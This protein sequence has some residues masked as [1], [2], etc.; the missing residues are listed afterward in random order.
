VGRFVSKVIILSFLSFF[1]LQCSSTKYLDNNAILLKKNKI[2]ID[3][4]SATNDASNELFID[5]PNKTFIGVPFEIFFNQWAKKDPDS[6]FN[7]WLS[8][9]EKRQQ[10]WEKILSPKQ[11]TQVLRYKKLSNQWLK[12]IGAPAVLLDS[13]NMMRNSN[14]LIQYFKNKGYFDATLTPDVIPTGQRKAEVRYSIQKGQQYRLDSIQFSIAA[15]ELEALVTDNMQES[16]LIP[17]A[18][19]NIDDFEAERKRMLTLFRNAGVYNFQEN[20]LSF[21]AAIDSSGQDKFIGI[22]MAIDNPKIRV[23]DSLVS[24]PYRIHWVKRINIFIESQQLG[25]GLDNYSD[26]TTYNGIHIYSKGPLKYRPKALANSLFIQKDSTYSDQERLLTYRYFNEL[27]NFKYPSITYQPISDSL[28][29]LETNIRLT[30]K[31]KFSLGLDF[32]LS[33]SNIQFFGLGL[34]T[35]TAIRNV[36]GGAEVLKVGVQSSFG[37]SSNNSEQLSRFFDLFELGSDLNLQIPRLLLPVDLDRIITKKMNPKTD[38]TLGFAIQENIGLDKQYFAGTYEI[39]WEPKTNQKMSFRIAEIEFV[40]NKNIDNYFNVYRNSYDR[41]NALAQQYNQ[42][43]EIIDSNN[44]LVI[45]SGAEIF[46]NQVFSGDVP[47][48][49]ES[50]DYERILGIRE[51]QQRLTVNNLIIGSSFSFNSN[52][53]QSL[54]DENFSQFRFRME[55]VGNL[56]NGFLNWT[57]TEKNE[58]GRFDIS[59]VEPSQYFKAEVDY[60]KHF[61]VG[62]DRVL[63]FRSFIGMAIPYGNASSIPFVRSYF[64]GGT[65]DNRAWK[66][67]RLGPGSS[68]NLNEFNEANFK[69]AANLEYRFPLFGKLKGALFVDAGN[70]WNLWDNVQDPASKWEG[71]QD[72]DEI[73]IGS[74]F[75][76]RY[77]FDFFVFRFDTAFKTYNPV[78]PEDQRWWTEYGINKAVFNVGINYPF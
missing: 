22:E 15:R 59:G 8:K 77:D 10:R 1:I 2:L 55:W 44:N 32:D 50:E 39:N 69:L 26:S 52:T 58:N 18:G 51:R 75:G 31:E 62:I 74:G 7:A 42:N 78:L 6:S 76:L 29:F 57:G 30:P 14:R 17:G 53:Q 72:L 13:T 5:S 25:A 20:S 11:L 3:G 64:A 4:E 33:H 48:S 71:L 38:L 63:A 65:N 24:Q 23:G 46:F 67:Y 66:A 49:I 41:L 19:F 47:L 37:A 45:P 43:G 35:S 54:L 60:I 73:A 40:N 21:T 28:P 68:E 34:G 70:I 27:E 9:K 61:P 36:L 12:G 16:F 56:F